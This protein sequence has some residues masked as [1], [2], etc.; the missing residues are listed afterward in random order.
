MRL[1]APRV[2]QFRPLC[3]AVIISA[4]ACTDATGPAIPAGDAYPA[5]HVPGWARWLDARSVDRIYL[6]DAHGSN[7]VWLTN[8]ETPAWSPDGTRIA[9]ERDGRIRIIDMASRIE[10]DIGEGTWPSWSP[11]GSRIAFAS[12]AGISVMNADGTNERILIRHEFRP[13]TYEPWDMGVGKPAWSPDGTRIAFEHLG[14]G[15]MQPATVY[16]M[17]ADGSDPVRISAA[18]T[19][20]RYA[21]SDP[22][23]AP[24][25]K[26]VAF[27]SYGL[28]IAVANLETGVHTSLYGNFPYVAYGATPAW[29]PDGT[30]LAFN[31]FRSNSAAIPDLL[32]WSATDE[33]TVLLLRDAF[34]PAWSPDGLRLAFVS[35]RN[36]KKK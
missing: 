5:V 23:W 15:D 2:L 27:W 33:S 35:N 12:N 9:F 17:K 10:Q 34:D 6:V 31:S 36:P 1:S 20:F 14:D 11:D 16:I 8:G 3:V 19:Q 29:S 30:R 26:R 28:G 18:F 22:A 13:D 24:D 7:P 4:A 25:G 21:E 32:V